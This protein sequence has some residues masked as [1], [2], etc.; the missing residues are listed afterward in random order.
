MICK[1]PSHILTSVVNTKPFTIVRGLRR[2][3][4]RD[5]K[6]ATTSTTTT[7]TLPSMRKVGI[8]GGTHGN[9]LSGVYLVK[10]WLKNKAAVTRKNFETTVCLSNPRAVEKCVRYIDTDL[11]RVFTEDNLRSS[12]EDSNNMYEINRGRELHAIF[13]PKHSDAAY[14]FLVDLHNTTSNMQNSLMIHNTQDP[15]VVQLVRYIVDKLKHLESNYVFITGNAYQTTRTVAK[16][17]LGIEIGPQSHGSLIAD[18]YQKM[19][20]ITLHTL[21]F[22]EKFNEGE[23]FN[24]CTIEAYDIIDKIDFP[25]DK[26]GEICAMIHPAF[27]FKDWTP[28]KPGDNIFVTFKGETI[29]YQGDK[30][31]YPAFINEASYYEK[32]IAFWVMKKVEL[33]APTLQ[34]KRD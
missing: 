5:C 22:I 34:M 8:L 7:T 6:M 19:E 12:Q 2:S 11:N 29:S 21:D 17:G 18:V 28:L 25:R 13:G 23:V 30:T 10:Q 3:R 27:Q 1:L 15:F 16:H 32:G 14:D 24:A 9:E 20:T 31:V 26:D 33:S 4:I